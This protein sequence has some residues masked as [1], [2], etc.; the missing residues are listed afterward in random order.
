M[1]SA[2]SKKDIIIKA[3]FHLSSANAFNL[4]MSKILL[5]GKVLIQCINWDLFSVGEES[6]EIRNCM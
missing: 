5:F 6:R 4:V 3:M 2:L 1:F